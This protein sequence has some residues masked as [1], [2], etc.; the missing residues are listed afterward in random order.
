MV[1]HRALLQ[2]RYA[3]LQH[4]LLVVFEELAHEQ[5][6]P[7]DVPGRRRDEAFSAQGGLDEHAHPRE[8][9]AGA[10]EHDDARQPRHVRAAAEQQQPKGSEDERE[11]PADQP[12]VEVEL[13]HPVQHVAR[14]VRQTLVHH[15]EVVVEAG[16]LARRVPRQ[17][18]VPPMAASAAQR[19]RA[20]A[21]AEPPARGALRERAAAGANLQ[22]LR[23]G[24]APPRSRVRVAALVRAHERQRVV[25]HE[26]ELRVE[27]QRRRRARRTRRRAHLALALAHAAR[28]PG[29]QRHIGSPSPSHGTGSHAL[30]NVLRLLRRRLPRDVR[31]TGAVP[32][33]LV[34]RAQALLAERCLDRRAQALLAER[35]LDRDRRTLSA[36]ARRRR[37]RRRAEHARQVRGQPRRC[38]CRSRT[39][40]VQAVDVL[41]DT[42]RVGHRVAK[43]RTRRRAYALRSPSVPV[44]IAPSGRLGLEFGPVQAERVVHRRIFVVLFF[45]VSTDSSMRINVLNN[46]VF[47][48]A[49]AGTACSRE[50]DIAVVA[51]GIAR[52]A[53]A[54]ASPHAGAVAAGGAVL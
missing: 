11:A 36:V 40:R 27:V 6:Q 48:G 3:Q 9:T 16:H 19:A 39:T 12:R 8:H 1:A 53:P 54:Y 44:A 45:G 25:P 14:E 29:R 35:G 41:I 17:H 34:Q 24:R 2:S 13:V 21:R 26:I 43:R 32:V 20:V 52:H 38:R 42:Q 4:A 49:R 51:V 28:A 7:G 15:V 23:G 46:I 37:G 30:R 5:L 22:L 50:R 31:V 47:A 10:E 18:A 33:L